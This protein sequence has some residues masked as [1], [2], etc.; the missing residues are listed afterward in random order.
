MFAAMSAAMLAAMLAVTAVA[1]SG[2][3]PTSGLAFIILDSLCDISAFQISPARRQ[4]KSRPALA[5]TQQACCKNTTAITK[6]VNDAIKEIV[7][8]AISNKVMPRP[9]V[10]A[11]L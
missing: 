11:F 4:L 2:A 7:N 8:E 10:V 9:M 3:D 6:D 1:V 5:V